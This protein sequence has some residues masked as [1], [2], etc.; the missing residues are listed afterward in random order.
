MKVEKNTSMPHIVD[1][2]HSHP[3]TVGP[4]EDLSRVLELFKRKHV[5][6]VAV[7]DESNQLLGVVSTKDCLHSLLQSSFYCGETPRVKEVMST[8]YETVLPTESLLTLAQSMQT[9][10][11][12]AYMVMEGRK[13]VGSI[14]RKDVVQLLKGELDSCSRAAHA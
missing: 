9:S 6:T 5:E 11:V 12:G 8:S 10:S 7:I 13:L 4:E 2:M 1:V 3:I 14:F